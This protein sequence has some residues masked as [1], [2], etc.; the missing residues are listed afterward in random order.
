MKH[1]QIK[2]LLFVAWLLCYLPFKHS[3]VISEHSRALLHLGDIEPLIDGTIDGR[4][5]SCLAYLNENDVRCSIQIRCQSNDFEP[6]VYSWVEQLEAQGHRIIHDDK[7]SCPVSSYPTRLHTPTKLGGIGFS[8]VFE[9]ASN[10]TSE[11]SL[12]PTLPTDFFRN[13]YRNLSK[14]V[15]Y[16]VIQ[17]DPTGWTARQFSNFQDNIQYLLFEGIKFDTHEIDY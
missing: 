15:N 16:F 5:L 6:G 4:W 2:L 11:T 9:S 3:F 13:Q 17:G 8:Q 7:C 10:L 1:S 12:M 14:H